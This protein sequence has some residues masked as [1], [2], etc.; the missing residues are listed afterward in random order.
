MP[1]REQAE[2]CRRLGYEFVGDPVSEKLLALANEYD[3]RA[4]QQ[5]HRQ[6]AKLLAIPGAMACR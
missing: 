2:R 6:G 1:D 3:A 5:A 4:A